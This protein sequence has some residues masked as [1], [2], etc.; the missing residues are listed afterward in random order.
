[1]F[2]VFFMDVMVFYL[3]IC[4]SLCGVFELVEENCFVD[5]VFDKIR[6]E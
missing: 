2:C 6:I 5:L 4:V 1:M 3:R